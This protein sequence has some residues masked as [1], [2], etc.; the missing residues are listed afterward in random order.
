[1][2][3]NFPNSPNTNDTFT[4]GSVTYKWDGEKWIGLDSS[5]S[6]GATPTQIVTGN[7]N[8]QT[9]DTGS[10]GHVKITTEGTERLRIDPSGRLLIG[11]TVRETT[12]D[13][14]LQIFGTDFESSGVSQQRYQ[15]GQSGASLI[16]AHSRSGTKGSHTILQENDEYGK[17]RFYGSDGVDFVN[18]GAEITGR[19]DGTPGSNDMPGRLEFM[20]T[21]D[22]AVVPTTRMTIKS[23]GRIGINSAIPAATLDIHD[24]GSTGPC[25]LLRGASI[26]E[27]DIVTPDGEALGFGNWNYETS[28]YTERLRIASDGDIGIG[29]H[30]PNGRLHV[31][32]GDSGDCEL[33]I[34][35]DEDNNDE[36]DH[37]RLVFM[38]DGGVRMGMLGFVSGMSNIGE[39]VLT[40]ASGG[41]SSGFTVATTQTD[42]W[43]NATRRMHID[44]TGTFDLYTTRPPKFRNT[45][46]TISAAVVTV[47]VQ[48]NGKG[49][50]TIRN[51]INI[52][53]VGDLGTGKYRVN[54]DNDMNNDNYAAV[55]CGGDD[56]TAND[57][58]TFEVRN[59]ES[60]RFD[61][62]SEDVDSGY[63]DRANMCAHVVTN[64]EIANY[65]N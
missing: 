5:L 20:T 40:L 60:G 12:S 23:D 45:G 28:T 55:A 37:P 25:L 35:A 34:E 22:G 27:G 19:V 16:L 59:F 13:F 10:D 24:L 47:M 7:T 9:V 41:G 31:T 53:S 38:Q 44:D 52:S 57:N 56:D 49:T 61:I 32:S 62:Y 42:G 39:N 64:S 36:T 14:K 65:D 33:I 30:S 63:V 17:I 18:Y 11:H 48:F 51:S 50:G 1:M 15:N 54:I 58:A 6:G 8:V 46:G 21:A 2:A 29:T 3:I 43:E 4:S 26:T